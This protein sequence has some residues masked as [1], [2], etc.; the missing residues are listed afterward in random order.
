MINSVMR[1]IKKIFQF[2]RM[3]ILLLFPLSLLLIALARLDNRWVEHFFVRFVYKPLSYA[4]GSFISLFPFSVTELLAV[5]CAGLL[6]FYLVRVTVKIVKNPKAYRHQLYK[7]FINTLCALSAALFLFEM[8]MG[9]NYYRYEA[10]YYL[11]LDVH[12]STV[13]ELYKL[14][15]SLADDINYYRAQMDEDE[16]GVSILSDSNRYETSQSARDAYHSLSEKYTILKAADIRN[17]PL[18]SSKLFST[19]MTTGIYIPY[20]FES[21]INVDVPAFTIPAT[22]CHELTHFRGFMRENEA[23][24]LGYLAC[25]ESDRADFRYSGAMLAFSYCYPQLSKADKEL[26]SQVAASVS[27]GVMRDLIYEDEYWEP[28]RNTVTADV[29]NKVYDGYLSANNQ[30]SGIQ[31]YGEMVDL[32]LAYQRAQNK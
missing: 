32:L 23:N 24:F 1:M 5:L 4:V 13:E 31:S 22:M 25:M 20:T 27:D 6:V 8:C 12:D 10:A 30:Q 3:Y 29:S 19:V 17:K 2:K 18:V 21:N 15:K 11:G 26:A 7:L 14:T 9:L 28:Y 16:N